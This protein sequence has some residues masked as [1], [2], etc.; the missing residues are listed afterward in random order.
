MVPKRETKKKRRIKRKKH[1]LNDL[2]KLG[3]SQWGGKMKE[4][5]SKYHAKYYYKREREKNSIYIVLFEI[6]QRIKA[7]NDR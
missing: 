1:S 2:W 3:A 7:Y 5:T 6:E 4:R